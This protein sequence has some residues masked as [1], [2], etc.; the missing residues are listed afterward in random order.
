MSAVG[1]GAGTATRRLRPSGRRL[2]ALA[3][4][5]ALGLSPAAPQGA[6]APASPAAAAARGY[7]TYGI[8]EDYPPWEKNVDGVPYG[9]NVDIV[10]ALAARL[11]LEPRFVAYPFKRVLASLETGDIDLAGGLEYKPER[12]AYALYLEPA[13]QKTMKVFIMPKGA[14][15]R[16]ERYE[17]LR[18]LR[19]G[20]RAGTKHFEPFDSDPKIVKVEANSVDQ[21]FQML[22]A[23]RFDVAIGG[24]IQLLYA[25]KAAGYADRIQV[26]DYRVNMGAGGQF[27]LSRL[28]PLVPRKA[29]FEAALRDLQASGRIDEIIA[30]HLR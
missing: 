27:A 18:A 8:D 4:L 1:R 29:E 16:L 5:C 15:T 22:L 6:A 20:L 9:I 24:N 25:A 10:R 21:L 2:L 17:D 28:S 3:A 14:G 12:A 13:Y 30:A 26:A 7:L 19:V 11:G 23:G